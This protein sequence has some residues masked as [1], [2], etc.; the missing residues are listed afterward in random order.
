MIFLSLEY[1]EEHGS[2]LISTAI[3]SVVKAGQEGIKNIFIYIYLYTVYNIVVAGQEWL[4][5][6]SHRINREGTGT[7]KVSGEG[8]EKQNGSTEVQNWQRALPPSH[9]HQRKKH[10]TP[11]VIEAN[12]R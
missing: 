3:R 9:T 1:N 5:A 6:S 7:S 2:L 11:N 8:K 12:T 4:L 10:S